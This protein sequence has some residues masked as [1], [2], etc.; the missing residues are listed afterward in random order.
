LICGFTHWDSVQI[1]R[2]GSTITSWKLITNENR[3]VREFKLM[4]TSITWSGSMLLRTSDW[5][6]LKEKSIFINWRTIYFGQQAWGNK[7]LKANIQCWKSVIYITTIKII[8]NFKKNFIGQIFNASL[9]TAE[10]KQT[11]II[12]MNICDLLCNFDCWS[13]LS[14][15]FT[16]LMSISE[17][18]MILTMKKN[19]FNILIWMKKKRRISQSDK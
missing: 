2:I 9:K 19:H 16:R 17:S 14:W 7:M 4:R 10:R 15:F 6:Q 18:D 11:Y 13:I 8:E 3:R 12:L 5:R 1:Y